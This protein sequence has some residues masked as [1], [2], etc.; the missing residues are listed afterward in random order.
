M[1]DDYSP[2][3]ILENWGL[4]LLMYPH[5][6]QTPGTQKAKTL[7]SVCPLIPGPM[8]ITAVPVEG[9]MALGKNNMF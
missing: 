2:L 4:E 1:Y 6:S 8:F 9:V 7:M 3:Y 5:W